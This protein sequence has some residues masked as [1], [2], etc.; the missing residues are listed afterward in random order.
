[1]RDRISG[2]V[3]LGVFPGFPV[4]AHHVHIDALP[5]DGDHA[6]VLYGQPDRVAQISFEGQVHIARGHDQRAIDTARSRESQRQPGRPVRHHARLGA[7]APHTADHRLF[8]AM[9][10]VHAQVGSC[11]RR[12]VHLLCATQ[13][14]HGGTHHAFERRIGHGALQNFRVLVGHHEQTRHVAVHALHDGRQLGRVQQAFDGAVHHHVGAGQCHH[15]GAQLPDGVTRARGAHR[16]GCRQCRCGQRHFKHLGPH[17]LQRQ[18]GKLHVHTARLRFGQN[19]HHFT[20][21]HFAQGEGA[22][23]R[24][25]PLVFNLFYQHVCLLNGRGPRTTRL[26]SCQTVYMNIH[27]NSSIMTLCAPPH[28]RP[29]SR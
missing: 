22:D 5:L 12:D 4:A 29:F 11:G 13:L 24:R 26:T 17:A 25:Q 21:L 6:V 3:T 7:K 14:L 1:M 18:T 9:F 23:K 28:L 19:G 16:G 8:V 27:V 20:R 2:A 10:Q 15:H